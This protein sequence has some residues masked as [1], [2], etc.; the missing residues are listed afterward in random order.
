MTPSAPARTRTFTWQD[1][2]ETAQAARRLHPR[3]NRPRLVS[4]GRDTS[5]TKGATPMSTFKSRH[6]TA[7]AMLAVSG[8]ALAVSES[9]PN[10]PVSSGQALTIE[11]DG[12]SSVF[13]VIGANS[14]AAVVDLDFYSFTGKEGDVVTFDID[15]GM[16]GT[17]NVDTI[18]A[19]YSTAAGYP[20][21]RYNDDG[22]VPLDAGSTHAYDSKIVN[23]RLPATGTYIVG[24][25]SYNRRLLNGGTTSSAAVSNS[26]A[27]G[28]YQLIISGVT[29]P[30]LQISIDIKPGNDALAP[31]NPKSKGKIPVALLGSSEFVV[32]DVDTSKLTF[33]HT[34]D[35]A[36]LAK[37]HG[38]SDVNGD[39]FPDMLC[40]FENQDAKFEATDDEAILRGELGDGRRFE[41]RSWLKVVPAKARE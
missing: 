25:S 36:S 18:M 27:N 3:G 24:V 10:Q 37:C 20:I 4:S 8:L 9:E 32:N 6:V 40:H 35:E 31:I 19:V 2:L 11:S 29:P 21:L 41:G 23:F 17:R 38:A 14:G 30:L 22:G 16:G 7:A 15:G 12:S 28:D 1:P 39:V 34:G 13:G 33:G 26:N 5:S